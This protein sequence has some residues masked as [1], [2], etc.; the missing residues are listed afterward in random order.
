MEFMSMRGV[1]RGAGVDGSL[2]MKVMLGNGEIRDVA[3]PACAEVREGSTWRMIDSGE[4]FEVK[5]VHEQTGITVVHAGGVDAFGLWNGP[6]EKF[7]DAFEF[8]EGK[9]D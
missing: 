6:V 3:G 1:S 5:L 7:V 2:A 8:V 9:R 4:L